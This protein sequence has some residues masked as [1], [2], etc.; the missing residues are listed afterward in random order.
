MISKKSLKNRVI[1][2]LLRNILIF[3]ILSGVIVYANSKDTKS[4]PPIYI[5]FLWHM[6]QPI[7]YPYEPVTQTESRGVYSF[8][9]IDVFNQRVGPYTSWPKNA[10]EKGIQAG[11]PHLGAQVSFSGS[12]IEN[13][14]V[15]EAAGN[16]NFQNW[17]SSWKY[18]VGQKTSLGNP[19]IDMI[20]FGY[21]H[22]LMPLIE[23]KEIRKQI[24]AHKDAVEK[25][26]GIKNY[27]KGIFTPENAFAPRIIPALVDEGIKWVLI[28]NI[29]FER[30]CKSYPYNISGNIV[31]PNKADELN[32][33]PNDWIQLNGVW[34][35]TKVSAKWAR[36]PHFIKYVDPTTGEEKKI[37][38]VPTDRYLGNEDG[39]G[40]F[41]ALN[42]E[43]VMSQ[44]ESFNTDPM[45]PILIVL[46][47]DGDNYGGGTDSYYGS[48]FQNFVNWLKNNP[49][50]FVC[51]TVQ[52]YLK[53]FPPDS[54]DVIHVERGSWSGADNGD[55]EFK[56]WLGD[57]GPD[58][59]S[60]DRNSWGVLTAATNFIRTAENFDPNN[61]K[62]KIA[63]KYFLVSQTS[64][65]WYW[66]GTEIWD[67]NPTRA[68]NV[69]IQKI[70]EI[71]PD[72]FTDNTPPTIFQPQREPYNPGATEWGIPQP[73]D[74]MVWT[75]VYDVKGLKSV[76]LKYRIDKDGI[77]PISS[78]DNETYVGGNEVG[79]WKEIT[80]SG[81]YIT[82]RTNPMPIF[83]AKEYSAQIKNLKNVLVDYYVEAEDKSGNIARSAI[84]HV[85]VGEN[86]SGGGA[87][88]VSISP[89][90]PTVNDTILVSVSNTSQGANLHWGVNFQ[91]NNWQT[92][93][94]VYWPPG[95][96][97]S[98]PAVE[99]PFP[100][101]DSLGVLS[102][103]MGP[104]NNPRQEVNSVA[105]VIHYNDNSWD[106]NNGHDYHIK[107]TG[108]STANAFIMDGN[109]DTSAFLA[110]AND[111]IHLYLGWES[112]NLYIATE[113]ATA[114]KGDIFVFLS[115]SV[116]GLK[117]APW[118]KSGMVAPW[119]AYIANESTNGYKTWTDNTGSAQVECGK[120][121]EGVI[122]IREEFGNIPP[123][124]FLAVGKY[125]TQDNG[126][127]IGQTPS[128]NG[129][130]NIDASEFL[131]FNYEKITNVK[132]NSYPVSFKLFQ[133][134]PNPFFK[135]SDGNSTT[136]I[137]YS[138]VSLVPH[139]DRS[140]TPQLVTLKVYDILGREIATLVNT[141]QPN[142]NYSVKFNGKNLP[143]GIYFYT[144]NVGNFVETKKMVLLK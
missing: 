138:I 11:L 114:Q 125:E 57:P 72:N 50:R 136:T 101:P 20:G 129:D 34:A 63:N 85:W 8:S 115:D 90:N 43:N 124:L 102:L 76:K 64:D 25:N 52:D 128:G 140:G 53:M 46:H 92:P 28:D 89:Q 4:N 95:S 39:R 18:I 29:H 30:A 103:K 54:T 1:N 142:G 10:V 137:K 139:T 3:I 31:E 6:H 111:G 55:P 12:L 67:S 26:F 108:D 99:T 32:P 97:Q 112:P 35:P 83:K 48:N 16:Q 45:H 15:L 105:F 33:D 133:N 9:I 5:A 47:H 118:G 79:D 68:A 62:I 109:L 119:S 21:Y 36:Q 116:S 81:K 24:N 17:K 2:N 144:L 84:S 22:P 134:Y 77:N 80:M 44:F 37:I 130:Y 113:P 7:Y 94:S 23:Y 91:G 42:Y 78:N 93:D 71:L 123:N 104:F 121:L 13:L 59:Y 61:P 41:G 135:G 106:N 110:S 74:F 96:Y 49:D 132:N 73:S 86:Q 120:Y 58:G 82:P 141:K 38:A 14:N 60:P 127:L 126:K 88:N 117:N 98:G 69:A 27:S 56:K 40:G 19:R 51:T 66:D 107:F 122:N 70:E 75:Y 100:N 143:S 87:G 65:Y 131:K